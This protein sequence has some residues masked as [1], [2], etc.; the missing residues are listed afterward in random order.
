M[1]PLL[2]SLAASGLRESRQHFYD[3]GTTGVSAGKKEQKARDGVRYL[4]W[5]GHRSG[6]RTRGG[7][8]E[9]GGRICLGRSTRPSECRR[10]DNCW[11]IRLGHLG[12][13]TYRGRRDRLPKYPGMHHA[14]DIRDLTRADLGL[15]IN[16]LTWLPL[17]Q[18]TFDFGEYV[19][20][21]QLHRL[22][23]H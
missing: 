23:S 21:A 13:G 20:E 19:R 2:S 4:A 3:D 18:A 6:V 22:Y 9:S 17:L 10:K 15:P 12:G 8:G 5:S 11:S 1:E 16:T 14:S 7:S